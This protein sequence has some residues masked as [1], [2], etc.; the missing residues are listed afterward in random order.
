[1]TP[2][3]R[4][5]IEEAVR[6]NPFATDACLAWDEGV[7]VV[8][9]NDPSDINASGVARV[10]GESGI[11]SLELALPADRAA[12]VIA[13]VTAGRRLTPLIPDTLAEVPD[14]GPDLALEAEREADHAAELAA[15]MEEQ[16]DDMSEAA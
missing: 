2:E 7:E 16:A 11:V 4:V 12:E 9:F 8:A 13:F 5:L 1:M 14:S 15:L 3:I 6:S 10:Y